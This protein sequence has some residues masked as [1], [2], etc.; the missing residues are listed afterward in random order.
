MYNDESV[1]ET[2]DGRSGREVGIVDVDG[3]LVV[4]YHI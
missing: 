3:N 1:L 4:I 2:H